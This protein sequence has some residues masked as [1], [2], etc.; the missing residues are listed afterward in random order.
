MVNKKFHIGE[1]NMKPLKS[2]AARLHGMNLAYVMKQTSL[3]YPTLRRI[4][5]GREN[6]HVGTWKA[7]S[8]FFE[9]EDQL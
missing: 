8:D 7:L 4:Q 5:Q 2:I 3:T 6:I 9:R 1:N